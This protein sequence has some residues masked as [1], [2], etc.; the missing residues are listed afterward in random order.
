M[1]K[2][3]PL[4]SLKR[5]KSICKEILKKKELDDIFIF[6]SALKGKKE[7][8]DIDLCFIFNKFNDQIIK[9][10]LNI[11][12]K[13]D[14]NV[15]ITK[16]SFP[17]I[18]DD[19]IWNTLIHEGYSIKKEK[20]VAEVLGFNS[21]LLFQYNLNNLDRIKK[22]SFSHALYGSGGRVNF[23]KRLNGSKIGKNAVAIPLNT[24]EGMR[25]FLETWNV[26]Y[27]V[28]RIWL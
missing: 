3:E 1:S 28:K 20:K 14:I 10:S 9:S 7:I 24:S 26:L 21:Y 4:K 11:F 2:K 23:L 22:Q 12:K 19:P 15:H 16:T 25:A 8:N 13:E 18:L 6:G 27:E 17:S 5:V